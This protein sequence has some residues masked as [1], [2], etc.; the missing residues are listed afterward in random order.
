MEKIA[1]LNSPRLMRWACDQVN[2]IWVRSEWER[3][4]ILNTKTLSNINVVPLSLPFDMPIDFKRIEKD[5]DYLFVGHIND[6][7]KNLVNLIKAVSHIGGHLHIAGIGDIELIIS[8]LGN[9]SEKTFTYLGYLTDIE[10]HSFYKRTKVICLPSYFEGVGLSAM[11]ANAF[12]AIP[13]I[14]SIGG[15]KDY[16]EDEAIYIDDPKNISQISSKL[17]EAINRSSKFAEKNTLFL[18][19]YSIDALSHIFKKMKF[20]E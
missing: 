14:T 17:K 11:E 10:L 6:P 15:A 8:K 5:I 1:F 2:E 19:K 7:R 4:A 13:A 3:N 9:V 20:F 12:G 18:N 16:F